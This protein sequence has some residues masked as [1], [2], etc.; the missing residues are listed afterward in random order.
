MSEPIKPADA[1]ERIKKAIAGKPEKNHDAQTG[2]DPEGNPTFGQCTPLSD[3]I[4]AGDVLTLCELIP[5]D[6]RTQVVKD[7]AMGTRQLPAHYKIQNQTQCLHH[8]LAEVAK[9][10]PKAK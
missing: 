8:L 5:K 4:A 3:K 6:S 10:Q 1:I 2:F 9:H 7:L